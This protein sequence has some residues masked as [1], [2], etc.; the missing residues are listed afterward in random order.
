[1]KIDKLKKISL[2][3]FIIYIFSVVSLI[4]NALISISYC[5]LIIFC[6]HDWWNKRLPLVKLDNN[7]LKPWCLFYVAIF[8][9]S[10][11]IGDISSVKKSLD[12]LYLSLPFWFVF[13]YCYYHDDYQQYFISS[14]AAA[15]ILI[16]GYPIYIYIFINKLKK[17]RVGG[18]FENENGFATILILSIPFLIKGM[19]FYW[20]EKKRLLCIICALSSI[21]GTTAL[22]ITGSR[23][24]MS[25]FAVGCL[26]LTL[27]KLILLKN[28]I[29]Y[30]FSL[31][32]ASL[33]IC[34]LVL[35][36]FYYFSGDFHRSYDNERVLLVKSSYAMWQDHKLVGIGL[37]NW[38]QAYSLKYISPLAKE[39]K[40]DMPHNT[41]AF[42]F[43]TTGLIG[44][45]GFLFFML[46]ILGYM[47][48]KMVAQ[49]QNFLLQAMI[50]AFAAVCIHGF[51][52][53]GLTMRT[54]LRLSSVFLGVTMAS[55]V[56]ERK[57]VLQNVPK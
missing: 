14:I 19:F 29:R 23:G 12:Y 46:G 21:M 3:F 16:S 28:P 11:L 27:A 32:I 49:P 50:W 5:V 51:V 47:C 2:S 24:G 26:L 13:Y 33:L 17:L 38:K 52:D 34:G 25:G 55:I 36:E 43:S 20:Q 35:G 40:I 53:A 22:V 8:L 37:T 6:I 45:I 54:A 41:I 42:F 15:M 31:V 57:K 10:C 1:M 44:G 30:K 56:L 18:F 4:S 48:K 39:P 7:F 9:S